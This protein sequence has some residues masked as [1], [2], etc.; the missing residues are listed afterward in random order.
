MHRTLLVGVAL[1]SVMSVSSP[2][3]AGEQLYIYG[4]GG[5]LPAMKE[6]AAIFE[7]A[8]GVQVEVVAG[9]TPQWIDEAKSDADL[10]FSG[11]EYMMSDIIEMPDFDP[12][13]ARALYLRPAAILV[14]P[15]NPKPIT[16]IADLVKLGHSIL[17]GVGQQELWE[18]VAGRVGNIESVRAFRANIAPVAAN[19]G[20]ARQAWVADKSLDAW[21]ILTIWQKASPTLADELPVEPQLA[22]YRDASIALPK[23]G[24]RPEAH[25]FAVFLPS[26]RASAIFIKWGW[27]PVTK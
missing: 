16:G 8:H 25:E 4:P 27:L 10:I 17:N 12:A 19:S 1:V 5:P 23:R 7:R 6:A 14:R 2:A 11:S 13:S 26:P 9:P 20:Q 3:F 24:E 18:E 22:I 21:L 15:E